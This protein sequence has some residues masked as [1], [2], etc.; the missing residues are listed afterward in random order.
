MASIP[1]LK[2]LSISDAKEK[3]KI[4]K[5]ELERKKEENKRYEKRINDCEKA[6]FPSLI[7]LHFYNKKKEEELK[8]KKEI[9][10]FLYL[11]DFYD[12][13]KFRNYFS[14]QTGYIPRCFEYLLNEK[15]YNNQLYF[16]CFDESF[17]GV[18]NVD[19]FLKKN[20]HLVKYCLSV[21]QKYYKCVK[22]LI[23]DAHMVHNYNLLYKYI[24]KYERHLCFNCCQDRKF[25]DKSL[26]SNLEKGITSNTNLPNDIAKI[27]VSYCV[28][29]I[30]KF[31]KP[32]EKCIVSVEF[33]YYGYDE[34]GKIIV[35][36]IY[37]HKK[38]HYYRIESNNY[39]P[40]RMSLDSTNPRW[41]IN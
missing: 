20:K 25:P 35:D 3:L 21:L 10:N 4:E 6:G 24:I 26:P 19:D 9:Q 34:F 1:N 36:E 2:D 32:F 13:K 31:D 7:S 38:K 18:I 40:F 5:K 16:E 29:P 17:N 41:S 30:E 27:I 37:C 33:K 23:I 12:K 14:I 8:D 11:I 15:K 22:K 39:H 28:D